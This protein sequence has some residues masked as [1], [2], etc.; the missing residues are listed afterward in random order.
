[1]PHATAGGMPRGESDVMHLPP[2]LH[3]PF[4][5]ALSQSMLL[6]AFVALFGVIA[7]IFMVG[8]SVEQDRP[9][10]VPVGV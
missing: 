10:E 2:F 3:A 5:A 9:V 4:A 8:G 1:M 7:A 6:P